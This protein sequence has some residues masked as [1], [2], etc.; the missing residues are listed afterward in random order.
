MEQFPVSMHRPI[1]FYGTNVVQISLLTKDGQAAYFFSACKEY[2]LDYTQISIRNY[3]SQRKSDSPQTLDDVDDPGTAG[4][5]YLN[6]LRMAVTNLESVLHALQFVNLYERAIGF[7]PTVV[8]RLVDFGYV[9]CGSK[10]WFL[11]P[12]LLSLYGLLVRNGSTYRSGDTLE[13]TMENLSLTSGAAGY[14]AYAKSGAELILKHGPNKVFGTD[15]AKNWNTRNES[16]HGHG[17][18]SF[19]RNGLVGTYPHW[20]TTQ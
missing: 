11:A 15:L 10:Q 7:P 6:E 14:W 20:M 12:P 18:V 13:E 3:L 19:S 8:K 2:M 5:V 9:F 16:I 4:M 1:N 17:I